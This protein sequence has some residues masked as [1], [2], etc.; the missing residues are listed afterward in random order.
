MI[1]E[2]Q[3]FQQ[4]L[5]AKKWTLLAFQYVKL[6]YPSI[7]SVKDVVVIKRHHHPKRFNIVSKFPTRFFETICVLCRT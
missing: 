5:N 2:T 3:L 7:T 4:S 1:I 6:S